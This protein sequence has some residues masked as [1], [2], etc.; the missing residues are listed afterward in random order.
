[1]K[2]SRHIHH[3][4]KV[5]IG[6][7]LRSLLYG[8]YN[9]LPVLF[10]KPKR[11]FKFDT[12]GDLEVDVGGYN[13]DPHQE[14]L[15][16]YL[17]FVLGVSGLLPLSGVAEK[18]RYADGIIRVATKNARKIKIKADKIIILDP[19]QI[20]PLPMVKKTI[21][22]KRRIIDW[23]NVTQMGSSSLDRIKREGDV[24]SEVIF[25]S[26]PR[27]DRGGHQD[28][29]AISYALPRYLNESKYATYS[30]RFILDDEMK[31]LGIKGSKGGS[32]VQTEWIQRYQPPAFDFV[33]REVE[34]RDTTY[35]EEREPYEFV[36]D[37]LEEIVNNHKKEPTGYLKKIIGFLNV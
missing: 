4:N 10:S 18:I 1:M 14:Q 26:S 27:V 23:I 8:Y 2:I 9:N 29:V 17:N 28:A 22:R 6:G 35:Y 21:K 37:T 12:L 3:H 32:V 24:M 34:N 7:D 20:A 30:F 31:R 19:D 36:Y 13:G 33:E 15:W 11:P 16:V 5:V 25:Y